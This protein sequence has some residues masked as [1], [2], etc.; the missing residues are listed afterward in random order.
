MTKLLKIYHRKVPHIYYVSLSRV[1]KLDAL[2]ILN[3]I[4]VAYALDERV[5]SEMQRLSEPRHEI[6]NNVVCATSKAS[7]Q[8]ARMHRLIRAFDSHLNIATV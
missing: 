4:Q 7:D 3:L 1:K 5:T 6:S 8:P 2:Y